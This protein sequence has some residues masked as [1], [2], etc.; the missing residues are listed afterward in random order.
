MKRI[1][2]FWGIVLTMFISCDD[3]NSIHQKY[4]DAGER[5]YMGLADSLTAFAG[6]G[7]V[8]LVWYVGADPKIEKTVIYW[9]LRQDS[10]VKPFGEN[11]QRDSIIIP[12]PEG[13]YD[14]EVVNKSEKNEKSLTSSIRA[15]SY[16]ESYQRSIAVRPINSLNIVSLNAATQSTTVQIRW[17]AVSSGCINTLVSYKKRSTGETVNRY[18]DAYETVTNLTDVGNRLKDPDD[19]ISVSS[20]YL[21]S[22]SIDIFTTSVR[23]E[24]VVVYSSSGTVTYNANHPYSG[25]EVSFD[26]V[27]KIIRRTD[28][29]TFECNRVADADETSNT[30][31]K[32]TLS[33]NNTFSISGYF[34]G[35]LNA[36]SNPEGTS[37]FNPVTR[38]IDLQYRRL[39]SETGAY[40]VITENMVPKTTAFEA[41]VLKPF[42]DMRYLIPYDNNTTHYPNTG[43]CEFDDICDGVVGD[44]GYLSQLGATGTSFTLDL[45]EVFKLSRMIYWSCVRA[46][47]TNPLDIYQNANA[48]KFE[49]W[50]TRTLDLTKPTSYWVDN[51]NPVGTFKADWEYLGLHTVPQQNIATVAEM[52]EIGMA[53][54][55]FNFPESA[56]PCR[57]VRIFVRDVALWSNSAYKD[58]YRVGELSFFGDNTVE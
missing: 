13:T 32:L 58:W 41:E 17:G 54:F 9:N 33:E 15:I 46:D 28:E 57:Y 38:N 22:G 2:I 37:T 45:H 42:G 29:N 19:M 53:G 56:E 6:N 44:N 26:D 16:G 51:E 55:K 30:L 10:V 20:F 39:T 31:F 8:K 23:Q 43:Y 18:V 40:S 52:V 5:V 3:M 36:L 14:F 1:I 49:I 50:G 21:P 12:L 48:I 4:I 7:R 27:A 25:N 47:V 24:Q 11:N 34:D 35:M